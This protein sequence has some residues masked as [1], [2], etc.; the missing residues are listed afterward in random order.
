MLLVYG[1][2][3]F[4]PV[5]PSF[6]ISIVSIF[7][8]EPVCCFQLH[9]RAAFCDSALERRAKLETAGDASCSLKEKMDSA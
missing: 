1:S 2:V 8:V 5:G 9:L 3:L 7:G 4:E 6:S